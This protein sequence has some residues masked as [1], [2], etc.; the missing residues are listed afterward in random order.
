LLILFNKSLYWSLIDNNSDGTVDENC[1]GPVTTQTNDTG[2][3]A[4]CSPADNNLDNILSFEGAIPEGSFCVPSGPVIDRPC[5]ASDPE[6]NFQTYNEG[7][8]WRFEFGTVDEEG[9]VLRN[10]FAQSNP[11]LDRVSVTHLKVELPI[12]GSLPFIVRYCEND[13]RHTQPIKTTIDKSKGIYQYGFQ[14][15]PPKVSI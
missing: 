11:I 6:N 3:G 15:I 4:E 10:I 12:P 5:N 14:Q 13:D 9:L 8:T 1:E 7:P 2:R